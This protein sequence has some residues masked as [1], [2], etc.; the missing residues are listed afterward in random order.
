MAS[1]TPDG[2]YVPTY[3][4]GLLLDGFDF[5]SEYGEGPN[6]ARKDPSLPTSQSH[7][8]ALPDG[9]IVGKTAALPDTLVELGDEGG[10]GDL[11]SLGSSGTPMLTDLSW[12]EEAEQDPDRLPES[13]NRA[14][15]DGLVEAW[16]VHRRTD[17][18]KLTP[19]VRPPPPIPSP[20]SALPGDQ[21]RS[22]VA[23][24][25][26]RSAFGQS[27]DE[28]VASVAGAVGG[29]LQNFKSDPSLQRLAS[30]VRS[31][32]QE[33]G[34][35]GQVYLRETAFPGLLTGK[36]DKEIKRRCA[37]VP[38]WLVTPGSKLSSYE[39]YLGKKVVTEIPW[40]KALDH[41]RPL[42]QASGRV[43]AGNNAKEALISALLAKQAKASP[44]K[45]RQPV[46]LPKTAT[47]D[48]AE[49]KRLLLEAPLPK[50][51]VVSKEDKRP[52]QA[53]AQV[54]RW[55]S[56]GLLPK[57]E[58]VTLL[59]SGLQPEELV[60]AA[61]DRILA[62]GKVPVYMGS[63]FGADTHRSV[64]EKGADWGRRGTEEAVR[65]LRARVLIGLDH[66]VT[67]GLL[68]Q[69]ERDKIASSGLTP[70][71]MMR[72]AAVRAQDPTRKVELPKTERV[73]YQGVT[74]GVNAKVS[75]P[76]VVNITHQEKK[77]SES[78]KLRVASSIQTM[79]KSGSL[80]ERDAAKILGSNLSPKEM[81]RVAEA[82]VMAPPKE[83]PKPTKV[84]T[85]QDVPYTQHV[86]TSPTRDGESPLEV[87]ALLRWASVKMT[88]GA[89]GKPF[90]DFIRSRFSRELV[91]SA[92]PQLVQLRR[93]HEG[94]SGHL[95]V[96]ASAYASSVGTTGCDKGA[97][98]HR[99]N[100][101]PSV[102]Q[103]P[104]CGSC[105]FNVD[106]NCQ[107]Y[108]KPLVASA[109]VEDPEAYR[110]Q[111]IKLANGEE[112]ETAALFAPTTYGSEYGLQNDN[113]DSIEQ[114]P[115]TKVLGDILFGDNQDMG[116]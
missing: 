94:L 83:A 110:K 21:L 4:S 24:A 25:M 101:I 45:G 113:L 93:K 54:T 36:W 29:K 91:A 9:L 69:D 32:R 88:E 86:A 97:L 20:T 14:V 34:V 40:D 111:T 44:P 65:S 100:A 89:A 95:Y 28:V 87:R 59:R 13:P 90:D 66:Y 75:L 114:F 108:N 74:Y 26:R 63:G 77:A 78:L 109:P 3:A 53:Q 85:Y 79:V 7:L 64:S 103:M 30:A 11:G 5:D 12:L 55:I 15:L 52:K 82:R 6:V 99:A 80:S 57:E 73:S 107:K 10:L 49:A 19:H 81:M 50:R 76:D 98:T 51:E 56:S 60:K 2:E 96:D 70:K 112:D 58:G 62:S 71:E 35:H 27:M 38:Y 72:A 106:G 61:A 116:L 43:A 84:A 39:N 42:L 22:I 41:F 48:L 17:G 68:T 67:R 47:V 37:S 1:S 102:L 105:V 18:R 16:G 92:E 115:E 8:S 31:I 33:H 104:R 46:T 23:S